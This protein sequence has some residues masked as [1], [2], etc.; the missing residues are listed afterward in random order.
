MSD[1]DTFI[2]SK[3][4]LT[5]EAAIFLLNYDEEDDRVDYKLTVD[6]NSDKEWL[7]LVKD[8]SAFANTRGGYIVFGIADEDKELTGLTKDV[9]TFLKDI[10]NFNSKINAYLDP[11][12]TL[13]R[14]KAFRFEGKSIVVVYIPQ[15]DSIT[16]IVKKDGILFKQSKKPKTIIHKGTFYVRRSS[17]NHLGDSRDFDDVV[18]RRFN[19]F[20]NRLISDFARVVN[21]P[22][23]SKT[24]ILSHDLED[25]T[26]EKYIIEDSPDSIHVKGMSFSVSPETNEDEISAWT[27]LSKGK[28]DTMPPYHAVWNWYSLRKDLQI[29]ETHKLAVFQ[30]SL[31]SAVPA[32]YWVKEIE[33]S[34][35]RKVLLDALRNR[36]ITNEVKPYLVAA[37]FLGKA[38]YK[39]A[40]DIL[41]DYANKLPDRMKRHPNVGPRLEYGTFKPEK[42][43]TLT[44]LK[45]EKLAELEKLVEEV[46]QSNRKPG[47]QAIWKAHNIDCFLHADDY[48]YKGNA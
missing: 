12:V 36:P 35:I 39:A 43:Q 34:K 30:F 4:P 3:D 14:A 24:F 22:A 33:N 7:S 27:V 17:T 8:A 42:K 44:N 37:S 28:S 10:N 23:D 26:G 11:E 25:V 1:L 19:Q 21:A 9:E 18:E 20:R 31:W 16:H 2:T 13:T 47:L 41:G 45:K 40:I 5:R 29:S 15:S 48:N 46:L 32:F 6:L 38:A